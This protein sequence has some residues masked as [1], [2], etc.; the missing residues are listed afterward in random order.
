MLYALPASNMAGHMSA[1]TV[2][3]VCGCVYMCMHT[4]VYSSTNGL[5]PFCS[6]GERGNTAWHHSVDAG[7]CNAA[8]CADRVILMH[9]VHTCTIHEEENCQTNGSFRISLQQH[10]FLQKSC[11]HEMPFPYGQ[12]NLDCNESAHC[13]TIL[14]SANIASRCL[15]RNLC[16]KHNILLVCSSIHVATIIAMIT[17]LARRC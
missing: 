13:K 17:R 4:Y 8:G 12:F 2:S 6:C 5:M 7:G 9:P 1:C 10:L 16:L 3:Q 11:S 14:R 15:S